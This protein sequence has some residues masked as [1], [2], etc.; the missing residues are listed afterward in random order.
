MAQPRAPRDDTLEETKDYAR[1][2]R[3]FL[4]Q[5]TTVDWVVDERR[6][7]VKLARQE[8]Q[9]RRIADNVQLQSSYAWRGAASFAERLPFGERISMLLLVLSRWI[10][11][12]TGALK[13]PLLTTAESALVV[14]VGT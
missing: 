9:M 1:V 13:T 5:F 8:E 10:S 14:L 4:T 12:W 3:V 11:G 6:E 7:R 2:S